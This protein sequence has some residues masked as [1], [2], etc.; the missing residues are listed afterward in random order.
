MIVRSKATDRLN[1]IRTF[2]LVHL[3]KHA[4][5]F[6]LLSRPIIGRILSHSATYPQPTRY[7][8]ARSGTTRRHTFNSTQKIQ[9]TH[10]HPNIKQR[11]RRTTQ[12]SLYSHQTDNTG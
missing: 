6:V 10:R 9:P 5:Q 11:T 3:E 12:L 2:L 4:V 7:P 8:Q 1:I